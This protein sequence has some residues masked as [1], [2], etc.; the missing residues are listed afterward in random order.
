MRIERKLGYKQAKYV[1]AIEIVDSY[2]RIGG[3]KGGLW[4]DVEGYDWYAGI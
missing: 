3:G 4:E 2:A 1:S